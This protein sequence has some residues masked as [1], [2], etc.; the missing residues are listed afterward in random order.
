MEEKKLKVKFRNILC[1]PYVYIQ[2]DAS[3]ESK[4]LTLTY[5]NKLIKF[6]EA[7]KLNVVLGGMTLFD[8]KLKNNSNNLFNLINATSLRESG[9]LMKNSYF[10]ITNDSGLAH[11]GA[12]VD[13]NLIILS[14][15]KNL[16]LHH[17]KQKRIKILLNPSLNKLL[18]AIDD[19]MVK[20]K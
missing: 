13:S 10:S 14:K 15:D 4:A 18:T 12:S 2:G 6:M 1:D 5:L 16:R 17:S 11:L 19:M 3:S 9:F 8:K 7:K 20:L